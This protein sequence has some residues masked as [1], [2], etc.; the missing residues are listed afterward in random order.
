MSCSCKKCIKKSPCKKCNGFCDSPNYEDIGFLIDNIES[1]IAQ[2]C[3]KEIQYYEN[4]GYIPMVCGWKPCDEDYKKLLNYLDVLESMWRELHNDEKEQCMCFDNYKFIK[5]KVLKII[6]V[7]R[8][9]E[10]PM[11][12]IVLDNDWLINNPGMTTFERWERALRKIAP[13]IEIELKSRN[14]ESVPDFFEIV[15]ADKTQLHSVV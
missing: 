4:G 1:Y 14:V 9:V 2:E 3:C 11:K 5:E 15:K 12:V 13:N 10:S 8:D 7:C 6:G